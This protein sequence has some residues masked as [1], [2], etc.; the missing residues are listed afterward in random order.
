[1]ARTLHTDTLT[2]RVMS[3]TVRMSHG[4]S[5]CLLSV[6]LSE[7]LSMCVDSVVVCVS[8]LLVLLV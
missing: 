2:Q 6:C 3:L 8:V 5:D 4:L 1:M 7:T